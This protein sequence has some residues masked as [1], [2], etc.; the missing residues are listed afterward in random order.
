MQKNKTQ[1]LM[2]I[3]LFLLL[4]FLQ[5]DEW[6]TF[7]PLNHPRAGAVSVEYQGKIYVLGGKSTNNTILNTIECYDPEQ[8]IW[9]DNALPP[10]KKERYNAAAVIFNDK[11]YLI[12][13]RSSNDVLD[14]VEVFNFVQNKWEDVQNI[15]EEREGHSAVILNN[16]I[17]VIGGQENEHE[18]IKKIEWYDESKD[19]WHEEKDKC[20]F[21]RVAAFTAALENIYYLFG[22]Y[23]YGL[24]SDAHQWRPNQMHN[25]WQALP[26]L[27]QARAY[28]ATIVKGDSI[29]LI[30]GEVANGKSDLVEI[31]NLKN[32]TLTIGP[33]LLGARSGMTGV[34]LN[35]T[36]F[37]IGG[38]DPFSGNPT[39]TVDI[40]IPTTTSITQ[41][42]F[43]VLPGSKILVT[44]YPNP[45]NGQ[46][47]IKVTFPR[48]ALY[49]VDI[50]NVQGQR[51]K[52]L[53]KGFSN[54]TSKTFIWQGKN[55]QGH[56]VSSGLYWLVVR[57]RFTQ[58]VFKII[59]LR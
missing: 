35:D 32:E 33:H 6:Q 57:S 14:E 13:G 45:F 4:G 25:N 29:Y 36:L 34:I 27:N 15:H 24:S 21:P 20:P 37:V 58:V 56:S 18:L 55:E 19:K 2:I 22:G 52:S 41:E 8:R 49:D 50:Y 12:G 9:L 11:I 39:N 5:A 59:Y 28:G 17:Y 10:F 23:Y 48:F 3:L 46:I 42:P 16:H 53:F 1:L 51:V 38:Y 26:A 30:G 44:G 43:V 54:S 47:S 40:L 7:V 31:F